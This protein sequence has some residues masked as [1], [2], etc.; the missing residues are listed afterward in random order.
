MAYNLPAGRYEEFR[1]PN[2]GSKAGRFRRPFHLARNGR[3]TV[4]C[5]MIGDY[6]TLKFGLLVYTRS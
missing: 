6:A 1:A 2:Y 4:A 3:A 5:F